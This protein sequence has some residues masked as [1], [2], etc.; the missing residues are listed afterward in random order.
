MYN[1]ETINNLISFL[2]KSRGK[3]DKLELSKTVQQ[4]FGLTRDR[5][6]FSCPD[7]SIR[8]CHSVSKSF[9]NTVL[10]LSSL[11]KY[12]DRPFIVCIVTPIENFSL[13]A[14]TTFITKISHSSQQLRIDNIKGSFNGSDIMRNIEGVENKPENFE[15][16]FLMHESFSFEEN[17]ERLVEKTNGIVPTGKR[18]ESTIEKDAII[19][20]APVRAKSFISSKDYVDLQNDLSGRIKKVQNEIAIAAFIDNVNIRG[21]IIE[22]LITSDG[23]TLKDQIVGYL[24]NK[25]PIPKF[26]TEDKLGDYLKD[27][28]C[29]FTATEIKTKVL[30]L[31]GNPKGY[32]IDKLLAF[33]SEP[34]SIYMVYIVGISDD[35]NINAVLCS[36]FDEQ[37]IDGT[38]SLFHWV[39]RNSRG[40]TQFMGNSLLNILNNPQSII[41]LEKANAHIEKMLA[42]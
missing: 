31:T 7:F 16:L 41:D 40:V 1:R 20:D 37:L 34:D 19:K 28:E 3:Y 35:G 21:R 4:Q 10:S 29:Y 27:Y 9:R 17:L 22:Y 39:G 2:Q 24:R 8:F 23:G 14:N 38:V 32:N 5:S 6:I 33:L 36:V 15:M 42:L 11:Q 13:L 26:K 25:K 30:F 18:F 12:D